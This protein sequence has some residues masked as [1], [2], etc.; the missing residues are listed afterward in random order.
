MLGKIQI[1]HGIPNLHYS[2]FPF[3]ICFDSYNGQFP[4][5][6]TQCTPQL[7]HEDSQ[8]AELLKA[9]C[10][11]WRPNELPLENTQYKQ[12]KGTQWCGKPTITAH[13]TTLQNGK[14]SYCRKK[15]SDGCCCKIVLQLFCVQS[16]FSLS[17][18]FVTHTFSQQNAHDL[19]L[20]N[21]FSVLN[22]YFPFIKQVSLAVGEQPRTHIEFSIS[23]LHF[24]CHCI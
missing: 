7:A 17:I 11:S 2:G 6:Y 9:L 19:F 15:D 12:S 1:Q 18:F 5:Q 23:I 24:R 21:I 8:T 14:I 10:V 20:K 16:L 22:C 3:S 13:R 4:R